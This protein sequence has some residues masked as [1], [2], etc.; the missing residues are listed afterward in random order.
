MIKSKRFVSIAIFD[1]S[2][3]NEQYVCIKFRF[4]LDKNVTVMYKMIKTAFRDDFS[5]RSKTFGRFKRFNDGQQLNEDY[6]CSGRPSTFR[7]YDVVL[8]ICQKV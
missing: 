8:I 6:P 4:K 5:I 2:E 3:I 7:N 1:M